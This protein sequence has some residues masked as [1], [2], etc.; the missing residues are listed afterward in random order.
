MKRTPFLF[1]PC[2]IRQS[3]S[4]GGR[5]GH[6]GVMALGVLVA[7]AMATAPARADYVTATFSNVQPG[8]VAT[9]TWN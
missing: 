4:A 9:I 7:M 1:A 3:F 8:E 5:G 6:R 2:Q